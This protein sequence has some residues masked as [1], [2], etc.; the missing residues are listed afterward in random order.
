MLT[1]GVSLAISGGTLSIPSGV[2]GRVLL[3]L[4]ERG[5]EPLP[6]MLL[7]ILYCTEPPCRPAKNDLAPN[8]NSAKV[9]KPCSRGVSY[10]PRKGDAIS[11]KL[12]ELKPL[13]YLYHSNMLT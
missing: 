12:I 5:I 3:A 8:V 11:V 6:W 7:D 1:L 9:E 4:S 10:K 13:I 2:G